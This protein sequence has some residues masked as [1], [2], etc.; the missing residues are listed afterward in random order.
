MDYLSTLVL[1]LIKLCVPMLIGFV[2]IKTKYVKDEMADNIAPFIARILFPVMLFTIFAT[3]TLTVDSILE[4]KWILVVSV[5][6][7]VVSF[8]VGFGLAKLL[9]LSDKQAPVFMILSGMSNTTYMGIPICVALFGDVF[10]RLG[11]ALISLAGHIGMWTIGLVLM[12]VAERKKV[13][14]SLKNMI[15][16][17]TV[18]IALALIIKFCHI[19]IPD[20]IFTPLQTLGNTTPWIALIYLGMLIARADVVRAVKQ[21]SLFVFLALKLILLPLAL[22]LVLRPLPFLDEAS[23]GLILAV[24][25]TSC[26]ISL[27]PYFRERGLDADYAAQLVFSSVTLSIVT[28]PLVFWITSLY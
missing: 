6:W 26:M 13:R 22:N 27:T 3:P 23:K 21:K 9:K 12:S 7:V 5:A 1:E 8:F 20:I 10:G 4:H 17:V 16:P 19:P 28:M 14:F 2:S 18:A 15:S 11:A 25:S 24:Y